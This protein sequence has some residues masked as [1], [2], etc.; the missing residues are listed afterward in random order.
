MVNR[1]LTGVEMKRSKLFKNILYFVLSPLKQLCSYT[2]Q[3]S[4]LEKQGAAR[5]LA[6]RSV[7]PRIITASSKYFCW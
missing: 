2:R 5:G 6:S 7:S 3:S 4:A 1:T